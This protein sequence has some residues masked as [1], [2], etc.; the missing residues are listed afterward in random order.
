[1]TLHDA[2][3]TLHFS[4]DLIFIMSLDPHDDPDSSACQ[5]LLL[6]LIIL[7]TTII[8]YCSGEETKTQRS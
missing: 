6:L 1:M 3:R 5:V 8:L 2:L 4:S 7:I